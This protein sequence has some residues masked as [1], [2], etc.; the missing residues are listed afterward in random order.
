M[1]ST[2]I[3]RR[4]HQRCSVRKGVLRNLT[5]FTGKHPCQSL[6]FDKVAGL[7]KT[8]VPECLFCLARV[9]SS[10]FCEISK[11]TFLTE[12]LWATASTFIRLAHFTIHDPIIHC[13]CISHVFHGMSWTDWREQ[14][15]VYIALKC[16]V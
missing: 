7:R 8:P 12:H 11:N 6:F 2:S 10:E 16:S 14:D 15:A 9:F 13:S 1:V 3:Y 5:K 4:S